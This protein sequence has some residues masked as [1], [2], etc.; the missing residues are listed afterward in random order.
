MAFNSISF[1]FAL[2]P[3]LLLVYYLLRGRGARNVAFVLASLVFYAAGGTT[4]LIALVASIVGNYVLG[5]CIETARRRG[6]RQAQAVLAVGV[7]GN[8][9]LLGYFKYSGFALG[10]LIRAFDLEIQVPA[11]VIITGVSF[12][13]F[14]AISYL[15]DIYRERARAA[16]NPLDTA[17]YIADFATLLA[18]PI[19]RW[20]HFAPQVRDR[21]E[22]VPLFAEGVERFII[23]LGKKAILASGLAA[24]N[25]EVFSVEAGQLAVIDAWLGAVAYTLQIYFDFSGYSDMAIGL[26]L[27]FGIRLPENFRWPY[28]ATSITDFWRRWHISLSQW[29]R[30]YVYIPLGGSR[31]GRARL[32]L[33]LLIVWGLTGL[34]HGAA[35]VFVAWGLYYGVLLIFEKLILGDRIDRIWRPVR[36]VAVVVVVVVGWV[37]FSAPGL[38]AALDRLQVMFGLAG[39]TLTS[40]R[41]AFYLVQYRFELLLGVAMS[42]PVGAWLRQRF[43]GAGSTTLPTIARL[44]RPAVLAVVFLVSIAFLVNMSYQPFIYFRF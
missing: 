32:V 22:S 16:R 31:V 41:T 17:L 34:W 44:A 35:W 6:V 27:M 9:G 25:A 8:L 43:M 42:M 19:V 1:L 11:V 2:L 21:R 36:H 13:T 7:L 14:L 4:A 5:L 20:E 33:N 29:F 26:G 10:T 39:A 23:G 18:G 37:L 38:Y 12:F 15:A 24:L 3:A 30:D 28:I 40:S